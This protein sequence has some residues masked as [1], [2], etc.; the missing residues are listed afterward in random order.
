MKMP[1]IGRLQ[2]CHRS[3]FAIVGTVRTDDVDMVEVS[4]LDIVAQRLADF[5]APAFFTFLARADIK[6]FCGDIFVFTHYSRNIST[7][8]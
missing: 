7:A 4:I 8:A 1:L 3:M 5:L 6:D 2:A